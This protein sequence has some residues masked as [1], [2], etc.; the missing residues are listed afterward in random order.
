MDWRIE[1]YDRQQAYK[2]LQRQK[3]A[4]SII[5]DRQAARRE[6]AARHQRLSLR[7]KREAANNGKPKRA[8]NVYCPGCQQDLQPAAFRLHKRKGQLE[9]DWQCKPCMLAYDRARKK[10]MREKLVEQKNGEEL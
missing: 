8:G 7:R 3:I 5:A 4:D 6:V 1:E 9:R 10:K 2:K